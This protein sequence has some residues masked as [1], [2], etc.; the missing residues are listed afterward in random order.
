MDDAPFGYGLY[1]WE[2]EDL[3]HPVLSPPTGSS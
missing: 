1:D 3:A 2:A